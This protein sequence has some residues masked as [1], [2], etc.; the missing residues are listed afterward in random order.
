VL[1]LGCGSGALLTRRL[2]KRFRVTGVELSTRMVE[3]ARRNVPNAAFVR[4]DMASVEFAPESFD[5]VSAFYSLI[6]LPP[7][8]LPALLRKVAAWLKPRGL[9]VASM[10]SGEDPGGSRKIGWEGSPCTSRA[11]LRRRTRNWSKRPGYASTAHAWRRSTKR[12]LG[13]HL[14]VGRGE[15]TELSAAVCSSEGC[16]QSISGR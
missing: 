5:G 7:G 10:G 11:T 16:P 3:L 2:A 8:E 12:A 4:G 15:E 14:P 6:H 13:R 9:F 1:D